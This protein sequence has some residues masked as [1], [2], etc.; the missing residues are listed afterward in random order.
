M[1]KLI[2]ASLSEHEERIFSNL[3]EAMNRND[4]SVDGLLKALDSKAH[5][6]SESSWEI[7]VQVAN[8]AA[9]LLSDKAKENFGGDVDIED[10]VVSPLKEFAQSYS[11]HPG[12]WLS[13]NVEGFSP[14]TGVAAGLLKT[15]RLL[16][17]ND[18]L[19]VDFL[20]EVNESVEKS[21]VSDGRKI[22]LDSKTSKYTKAPLKPMSKRDLTAQIMRLV[23][24]ITRNPGGFTVH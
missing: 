24:F 20:Q 8:K 5:Q 16:Q 1:K 10:D 11:D 23:D 13:H 21:V 18:D 19:R 12:N 22:V 4:N 14:S 7:L 17:E 9:V 15:L 3:K 6:L 2:A